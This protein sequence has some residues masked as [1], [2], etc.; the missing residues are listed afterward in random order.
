MAD[1]NS[2]G[3]IIVGFRKARHLSS[4][5]AGYSYVLQNSGADVLFPTDFSLIISMVLLFRVN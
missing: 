4:C 5:Y 3:A 2:N 1:F